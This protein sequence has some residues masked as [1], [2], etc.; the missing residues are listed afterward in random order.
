MRVVANG[1]YRKGE[2]T[3]ERVLNV[4][5]KAFGEASFVAV[6]TRQIT[7]AAGGSLPV[8]HCYF[9]NKEGL[10]RACAEAVVDREDC[11]SKIAPGHLKSSIKALVGLLIGS[12]EVEG[13]SHFVARELSTP[14]P[15]FEIL[16]VGGLTSPY[17]AYFP[18]THVGAIAQP[19]LGPSTTELSYTHRYV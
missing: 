5:L 14:G 18:E 6:R 2:D 8:L 17:S 9:G 1:G 7:E 19:L 3:R 15:A 10:Y 16:F 12:L 13:W 4:A 11:A